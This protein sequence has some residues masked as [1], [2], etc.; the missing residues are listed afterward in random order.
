MFGSG[1]Q[2]ETV[3]KVEV[4][5]RL[6]STVFLGSATCNSS[7]EGER[8]PDTSSTWQRFFF[9]RFPELEESSECIL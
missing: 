3:E 1:I 5:V 2:D 6:D 4:S 7:I 8:R 9:S